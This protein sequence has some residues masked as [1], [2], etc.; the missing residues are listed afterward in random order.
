MALIQ[1]QK[2][3]LVN[4]IPEEPESTD[5]T[6]VRVLIKLPGGQVSLISW[7]LKMTESLQ[8]LER[9]FLMSHS[10]RH[11]YYF[12]FC[13]PDRWTLCFTIITSS[14]F[15][16][17]PN[18]FEIVSNYPKRRLACKPTDEPIS[19]AEAGFSKSEMLFVNDLESWLCTIGAQAFL[20]F[21]FKILAKFLCYRC[22]M[23]VQLKSTAK[24]FH[25]HSFADI[26]GVW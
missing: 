5:P 23:I 26:W 3:D 2:I 1:Q 13:H 20:W 6:A 22:V 21:S 8:R 14:N 4:E 24:T 17:S 16:P 9:R 15:L 19:L 12:V 7:S 10:L 18:E 25:L 11:I